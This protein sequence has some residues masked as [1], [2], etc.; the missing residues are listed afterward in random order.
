ME[1]ERQFLDATGAPV[2]VGEVYAY[3]A[4]QNGIWHVTCGVVDGFTEERVRLVNC[5]TRTGVYGNLKDEWKPKSRGVSVYPAALF[6][7]VNRFV[8]EQINEVRK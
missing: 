4:N 6:P 3:S 8:I 7:V 2:Y 5:I 1:V